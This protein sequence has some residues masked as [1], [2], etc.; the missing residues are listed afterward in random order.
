MRELRYENKGTSAYLVYEIR[1]DDVIDSM[2]LGML[3]NNKIEGIAPTVFSQM[4]NKKYVKFNISGK[5]SAAQLFEGPVNKKRL[6]GVLTG[7]ITAM[8]SAEDYMLDP[9]A[10]PLGLDYIF[11]DPKTSETVMICL[12]IEGLSGMGADLGVFF[13]NI[14]FRTQFDQTENCDHVAQILNFLNS[15]PALSLPAF[16]EL[17]DKVSGAKSKAVTYE[18]HHEKDV[19]PVKKP[20]PKPIVP[21]PIVPADPVIPEGPVFEIPADIPPVDDD[22]DDEPE[23]SWFYLMQHYSK[24]NAEIYK[25]QQEKKKKKGQQEAAKSKPADKKKDSGKDK[26]K[27]KDKS[28]ADLDLEFAIPGQS[29][30]IPKGDENLPKLDAHHISETPVKPEHIDYGPTVLLVDRHPEE[31]NATAVIRPYLI[32]SKTG[33]RVDI[34]GNAFTIGRK[35]AAVD[36]CI[37]NNKTVS[38]TH[39]KIVSHNGE[40]FVVD[41][42]SSNYTYVN[43]RMIQSNEE[44]IL[45]DGT[46]LCFSDEDFEFHL[47]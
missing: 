15:S 14:I 17:L 25:R 11:V 33:E 5:V 8:T 3:T 12:P 30:D 46:K 4:D 9:Q 29:V 31:D 6:I 37:E 22:D 24:E 44:V 36:Y 20:E 32:R 13:K 7:I 40:Y 27:K 47:K 16:K 10:L 23:M 38:G 2:S 26:K 18:V 39:A 42:N 28:S 19:P 21:D 45:A 34:H 43:G 1:E 35:K 41:L